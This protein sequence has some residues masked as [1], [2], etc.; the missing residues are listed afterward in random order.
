MGEDWKIVCGYHKGISQYALR[1]AGRNTVINLSFDISFRS[2]TPFGWPQLCFM[3]TGPDFFGRNI[4]LGYG[5]IHYPSQA[6]KQIRKAHLF[7]PE[8]K[9]KFTGLLGW[10]NGC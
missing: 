9:S 4:I 2:T 7:K 3:V 10:L 8:P 6:G 1:Q 5:V